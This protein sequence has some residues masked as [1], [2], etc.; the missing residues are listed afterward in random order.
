MR[1]DGAAH[2]DRLGVKEAACKVLSKLRLCGCGMRYK[3][4]GAAAVLSVRCLMYTPAR[5]GQFW[6]RI[7]RS[8]FLV[9]A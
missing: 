7:D 1:V 5:L 3:E 9:A 6:A 8:G 2:P 4:R